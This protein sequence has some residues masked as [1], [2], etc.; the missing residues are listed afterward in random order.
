[1]ENIRTNRV[2][3]AAAASAL[4]IAAT[5][6]LGAG[7]SLAGAA[8]ASA[9]ALTPTASTTYTYQ[10][11]D[12]P[13]DL[14]FNQLLGINTAGTIAGYYGMN[15][16]QGYT[17]VPP[18]GNSNFTSE[19]FP[20][21]VQ[22]QVTGVNSDPNQDTS[23]FYVDGKGNQFGF[24]EW[25]GSFESFQDPSTPHITGRVNQ[26][27]GVNNAG[28]AVGFY[29][30]A[31]NNDHPYVVNQATDK[32]RNFEIEGGVSELA[33]GINNNNDVV[34]FA[35]PADKDS[36]SFLINDS[37]AKPQITTLQFPGGSDTEA[38]GINDNNEIVGTYVDGSGVMHGFTLTNP[39]GPQSVWQTIDEPNALPGT[40]VVN[41]LNNAGDLVGFYEDTNTNT[42]GFLATP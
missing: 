3:R 26:L 14:T 41:G 25:N 20:G 4:A 21:S 38:L 12:N 34:G 22:T 23:G 2:S 18:Y 30:D 1:M 37:G 42:D 19:N 10:T 17:V 28:I 35:T 5:I 40:T 15:I 13:T 39:D 36:F 33:T 31:N 16:N 8:T 9:S 32:F 27:L 6:A 7:A 24:V 29:A 11:I